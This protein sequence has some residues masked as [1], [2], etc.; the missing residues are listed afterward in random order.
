[1]FERAPRLDVKPPPQAVKNSLSKILENI[2]D[3]SPGLAIVGQQ[4][5]F[6]LENKLSQLSIDTPIN[7]KKASSSLIPEPELPL[8][9]SRYFMIKSYTEE[10]VHKAIKYS[11]WSSTARGNTILDKAFVEIQNFKVANP[12]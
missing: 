8:S 3:D 2:S 11:I 10:D 4:P 1:M 12:D 5:K 7:M 6:E 9:N